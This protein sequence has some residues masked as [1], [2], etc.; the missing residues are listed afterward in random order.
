MARMID[1]DGDC[2]F[3]RGVY[4]TKSNYPLN[5]I[6]SGVTDNQEDSLIRAF[7]EPD[8]SVKLKKGTESMDVQ[9]YIQYCPSCGKRLNV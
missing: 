7:I 4:T 8:L 3:C 6:S 2:I 5:N 9:L 1:K